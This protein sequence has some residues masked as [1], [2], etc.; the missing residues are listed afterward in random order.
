VGAEPPADASSGLTFER[1]YATSFAFVWRSLR[2]LGLSDADCW[3]ACQEVFLIVHR[4]LATFEGRS[5]VNT[6]LYRICFRTAKDF[7]RRA[8]RRRELPSSEPA[9]GVL[10]PRASAESAAEL[11]DSLRLLERGLAAMSLEQRAVFTLFELE[12]LSCEEI[13][14][15][16]QIPLGTVHSRLRRARALFFDAVANEQPSAAIMRAVGEGT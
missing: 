9:E 14:R 15:A 16:L 8:H 4:R 7:R 3:D 5:A 2:R 12:E 6:W 11:S 1:V 10:D 13:A